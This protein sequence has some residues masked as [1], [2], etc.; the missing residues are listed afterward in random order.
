MSRL[1]TPSL[2][3]SSQQVITNLQRARTEQVNKESA[4]RLAK[5]KADQAVID[6]ET[7]QQTAV[8]ALT[9]AQQTQETLTWLVRFKIN[10][11]LA[12]QAGIDGV[13]CFILGGV[14][15]VSG[16]QESAYLADAMDRAVNEAGK[17]GVAAE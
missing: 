12:K 16:A 4:A 8:S 15:A 1:C 2:S 5:E 10:D 14:L 9:Q 17:R 3:V 11:A 6:A 7:S 13:P